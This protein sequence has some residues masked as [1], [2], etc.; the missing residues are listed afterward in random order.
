[1]KTI[2]AFQQFYAT[3]LVDEIKPIEALRKKAFFRLSGGTLFLFAIMV[4]VFYLS[5]HFGWDTDVLIGAVVVFSFL[6]GLLLYF[7]PRTYV[8]SF[9]Q[10]VIPRIVQFADPNLTYTPDRYIPRSIFMQSGIF[11]KK[12]DEYAGDDLVSGKIGATRIRF[13]EIDAV[14]ES[15]LGSKDGTG[16]NETQIFKG[17]FIVADF[18]KKFTGKT[19]VLTDILERFLGRFGKKGLGLDKR[20]GQQINLEDPEF[21]KLFEVYGDDQITSRYILSTSL[22]ARLTRFRKEAR[23]A[24]QLSFVDS[25]MYIAIPYNRNLFEPRLFRS[26]LSFKPMAEY[27]KVLNLALGVIEDMNLNRRIWGKTGPPGSAPAKARDSAVLV[28]KGARHF[29][30]GHYPQAIAVYSDILARDPQNAAASFNRG[31]T[32]IRTGQDEQAYADFKTAA[33]LGHPKAAKILKT[34][35]FEEFRKQAAATARKEAQKAREVTKKGA[36]LATPPDQSTGSYWEYNGSVWF[37]G[38]APKI[39][40]QIGPVKAFKEKVHSG[41][42]DAELLE[43]W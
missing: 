7:L 43:D 9:K 33:D 6:A 16:K 11:R 34:P 42:I 20:W 18:N 24:I 3:E 1:M 36:F 35:A 25:Q 38:E 19:V 28:K 4:A 21:E 14:R 8:V 15:Y 27:F 41:E 32:Y 26:I 17:L 40:E 22:M 29:K 37:V 30:A 39:L 12:P 31:V 10:Q 2:E 5:P 23:K 13:S